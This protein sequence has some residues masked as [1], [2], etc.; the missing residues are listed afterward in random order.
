MGRTRS[1]ASRPCARCFG[2]WGAMPV[3]GA[4]RSGATLGHV[5]GSDGDLADDLESAGT[6]DQKMWILRVGALAQEANVV[7]VSEGLGDNCPGYSQPRPCVGMC[8]P[9]GSGPADWWVSL[10]LSGVVLGEAH[11]G[12]T[13]VTPV[14]DDLQ[15]RAEQEKSHCGTQDLALERGVV[16]VGHGRCPWCAPRSTNRVGG[17]GS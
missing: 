14:L 5:D 11:S 16:G 1:K 2:D 17:A 15:G 8:T 6:S 9:R 10:S 13:V 4:H 12:R 7:R 3:D